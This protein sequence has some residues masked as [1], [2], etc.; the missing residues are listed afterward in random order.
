MA[1]RSVQIKAATTCLATC[2]ASVVG[3]FFFAK[4]GQISGYYD[5]FYVKYY[6]SVC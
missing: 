4:V 1:Y 2:L 3:G 5:L 6:N